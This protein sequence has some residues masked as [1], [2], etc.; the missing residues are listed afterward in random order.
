MAQV[1]AVVQV[2]SMGTSTCHQCD[3]KK[4]KKKKKK[5]DNRRLREQQKL[6][7]HCKSTIKFFLKDWNYIQFLFGYFFE[8]HW[9]KDSHVHGQEISWGYCPHLQM[10]PDF[11]SIHSPKSHS[12]PSSHLEPSLTPQSEL[13]SE[14]F[15]KVVSLYFICHWIMYGLV[16]SL[17]LN[18]W[19]FTSF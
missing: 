7:Q 9:C 13:P 6:A 11:G 10:L 19:T 18:R 3:Q 17:L 14:F 8:C 16:I 1:T 5:E 15:W 12:S 4:K 2:L